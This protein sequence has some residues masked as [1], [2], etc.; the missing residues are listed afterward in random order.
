MRVLDQHVKKKHPDQVVLIA[1]VPR[2]F[3][4]WGPGDRQAFP[5]L[6]RCTILTVDHVKGRDARLGDDEWAV[7]VVVELPPSSPARRPTVA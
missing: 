5:G 1:A 4:V 2:G 3:V 7:E 6:G